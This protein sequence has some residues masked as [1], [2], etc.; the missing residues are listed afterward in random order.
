MPRR[1]GGSRRPIILNKP[2]PI[3]GFQRKTNMQNDPVIPKDT[4]N[5]DRPDPKIRLLNG[6]PVGRRRPNVGARRRDEI[7]GTGT[8]RRGTVD[9]I[10]QTV[11]VGLSQVA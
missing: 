6:R 10:W 1:V 11:C 3:V 8:V 4:D 2:I 7:R 5:L 9:Y